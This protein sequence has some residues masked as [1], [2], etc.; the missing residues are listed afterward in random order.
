VYLGVNKVVWLY[1]I[2]YNGD[3]LKLT[4]VIVTGRGTTAGHGHKQTLVLR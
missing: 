4:E 3:R 2:L 1:I